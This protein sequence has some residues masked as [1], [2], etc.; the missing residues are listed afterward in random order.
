MAWEWLGLN[1][2]TVMFKSVVGSQEK[3]GERKGR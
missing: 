2:Y 3:G 1:Q